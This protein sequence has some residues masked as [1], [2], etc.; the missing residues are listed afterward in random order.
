MTKEYP[1]IG[2]CFTNRWIKFCRGDLSWRC[3]RMRT[4]ERRWNGWLHRQ[5]LLW[6]RYDH[7]YWFSSSS[8]H[9]SYRCY[10]VHC[11]V[12]SE[13]LRH[14]SDGPTLWVGIQNINRVVNMYIYCWVVN[15]SVPRTA[16]VL[17]NWSDGS[18]WNIGVSSEYFIA[19]I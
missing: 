8:N 9:W 15:Y 17:V 3:K 10:C 16:N 13:D 11:W 6:H 5:W 19:D 1:I 18:P 2:L 4:L 7:W 12:T 14:G